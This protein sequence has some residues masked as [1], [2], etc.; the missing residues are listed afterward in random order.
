MLCSLGHTVFLYGA[1]SREDAPLEDYVQ[2]ETFNFVETHTVREIAQTFGTGDNRYEVSYPWPEMDYRHDFSGARM[3]ITHRFYAACIDKISKTAQPDHFLLCTQ[4]YY[5]KPIADALGLY[6]TVE[7]GIG[8]RGPFARFR[9]YESDYIRNFVAGSEHPFQCISGDYYHRTIPN[10][11]DSNDIEF[12]AEKDDYYLFIGRMIKRKGVLAADL[13]CRHLGKK[14]IIAGQGA[15]V[16]ARVSLLPNDSPDFEL[17]PGTWEYVGYCDVER[18]KRLMS[19]AIATFTPT[20]YLECFAGTHAESML[21]G[22]P[23]IT[24]S[25]GVFPGTIPD[26]VDGMHHM[27][28]IE[29]AVGFKCNTLQDFVDAAQK[30]KRCKP[31]VVRAYAERYLMDNVAK[32]YQKWFE[33]LY[34]VYLSTDGKTKGWHRLRD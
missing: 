10:Y 21:S 26:C 16:T 1:R 23:V 28:P 11:F 20:E 9:A 17:E 34:Q 29:N 32:E 22:T 15:H 24:T 6:L 13:A 31:E 4:G 18:R 2:S 14:L 27:T 19:R 30:A 7:P 5:H 3:P 8:Y 25:F 33:D 12:S